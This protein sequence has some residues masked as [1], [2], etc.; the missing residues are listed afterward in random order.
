LRRPAIASLSRADFPSAATAL[1]ALLPSSDEPA[2]RQLLGLAYEGSG[3]LEAAA[4]QFRLAAAAQ[5]DE[6]GLVAEGIA[7]LLEGEVD[8]AEA[9]F[10]R[11][12]NQAG[13]P[14]AFAPLGLGAALFQHGQVAAA[15]HLLLDAGT[16]Q[17]SESAPFG[18]IAIA[19]R[20]AEPAT[21]THVIDVLTSLT[22]RVPKGS[23]NYALACALIAAAGGAPDGP[24]SAQ[25]EANLK[26]AVALDPQLADAHFRLAGIYAAREDLSSAIA[27]YRAALDCDPR[28]IEAHY[29]LGQ[30]YVRSGQTQLAADQLKLHQ[31]L[32]ARQKS[33]IES[34]SVP[35]HLPET[36][37]AA[38]PPMR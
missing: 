4:E 1:E 16:A 20:S 30:L 28:L 23:A 21:L 36:T 7:L 6:A 18:F 29:R 11:A 26:E 5:P 34:G 2:T 38:C 25:I 35:I 31:Q 32:R 15:L 33:E 14:T 37:A 9:I 8:G 10:R 24:Q 19:V 3:Q 22:Q 13:G 12:L 27:E 17:P